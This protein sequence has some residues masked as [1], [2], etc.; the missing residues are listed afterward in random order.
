MS[1]TSTTPEFLN[2]ETGPGT[3]WLFQFKLLTVLGTIGVIAAIV[4]SVVLAPASKPM[5]HFSED[6]AITAL[7]STILSIAS[8]LA[9]VVFY[10]RSNVLNTDRLF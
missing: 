10:L 4:L 3:A 2:A 7:S 5:F 9:F 6:G 1:H 8:A